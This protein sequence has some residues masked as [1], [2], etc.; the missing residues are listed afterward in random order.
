MYNAVYR[1]SPKS[2][3]QMNVRLILTV[4]QVYQL[5]EWFPPD[6]ASKP[7]SSSDN[8]LTL[9]QSR[10]IYSFQW[11]YISYVSVIYDSMYNILSSITAVN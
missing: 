4:L 9:V 8:N 1:V 5:K 3:V 11:Y 7:S 6:L 2:F 10:S